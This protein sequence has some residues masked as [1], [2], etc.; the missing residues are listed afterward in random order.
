M[1]KQEP[2]VIKDVFKFGLKEISSA[3]YKHGLIH[4][5]LGSECTT[6][7]EASLSAWKIYETFSNPTNHPV[8]ID[9]GN[10]NKFDVS[11]IQDILY[12][13]RRFH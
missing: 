10:Y 6:G 12:Y 2:I 1:F 4:T 5:R 3:M 7:L 13:L 8:I 11:V 9:I